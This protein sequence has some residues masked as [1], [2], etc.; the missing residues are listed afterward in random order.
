[1]KLNLYPKYLILILLFYIFVYKL[2]YFNLI[3]FIFQLYKQIKFNLCQYK[4]K[5]KKRDQIMPVFNYYNSIRG[6]KTNKN[7]ISCQCR[8]FSI[9]SKCSIIFKEHYKHAMERI[10]SAKVIQIPQRSS[11]TFPCFI[12]FFSY[13]NMNFT[14]YFLTVRVLPNSMPS[15]HIAL[16]CVD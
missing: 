7:I 9:Q 12:N 2:F 6:S 1:M 11:E 4:V 14:L 8:I 10:K 16:F 5:Y 15:S 13:K 3:Y